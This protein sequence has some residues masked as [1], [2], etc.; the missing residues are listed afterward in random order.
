MK[1]RSFLPVLVLLAALPAA[2]QPTADGL[3]APAAFLGYELGSRFTPHHRVVAYVEHVTAHAPAVRLERYG[4]TNEGR[5]LL[6]ATVTTPANRDRLEQIRTDNLKRAG[7]LAGA[8]EGPP[9][10]VVWLSYNVH[11][12]ESVS[13]EAALQTL[14]ELA[15]PEDT[16]T[17]AWLANTVVLLDPCINPDGRDRYVHWY[18]ETV[19][20][21]PD[22]D[23]EARE[24]REPWPGGRANHYYF[25]LNR[26]WA[27]GTQQET[28]QRLARY[29]QWMPHI[30]V[31]FH[32]QGVDE[33]YFFAPAAEPFHN[34]VT[35]WQRE[36]QTRIGK[37]HTRYFDANH[38]LYFT[39]QRFDLFYPGYGDTWP[40]FNGAVGMTYEQGGSGRAGLGI[41]T[42]EGDTLTLADRIAHH[43]TTGLSTVETAARDAD[44]IVEEFTRYFE[45][46]RTAPAAPYAAYVVKA[47]N[48]DKLAALAAHL[49]AQGIA[50]GYATRTRTA[51]GTAYATGKAAGVTVEPGDLVV[52]AYQPRRVLASVLF[53]PD[54]VLSDS[55]S[56]DVTAW[57]LPY[58]YGL[59]AY[60]L[61]TRLDPDVDA[62]QDAAPPA[63]TGPDRPYAYLAEWRSFEDLQFLAAVLR[64]G[65][66]LRFAAAPFVIDGR[67]YGRGTLIL[68]R[69]GNQHLGDRFDRVVRRAAE[70]LRQPLHGV[71][72][73]FVAE[74]AD[75]G[76]SD[77]PFLDAPAVAVLAGDPVSSYAAGEVWHFF[78]QQLGYP[79]TLL[80]PDALGRIR[81]ADYDV[82][83]LPGGNYGSVLTDERLKELSAWIRDGGRLVALERAAAF[84]AGKEGFALQ[85]KDDGEAAEEKTPEEALR[86]YAERAR[87]A[88]SGD[89]TGAI[90]R[91]HL[92]P[93]HPLAFGY[94]DATFT[95]KRNDD[96]FAFLD[97][98]WNVGVLREDPPLGG[99]AGAK[100]QPPLQHSL[101]FGVQDLGRGA[102][103]Y[104]LDDVLFRGF[105]YN[106]RLLFGNAVFLAGRR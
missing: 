6:L 62:A 43:H 37:N 63:V 60:A 7:L 93:T 66:K 52:S 14:Y 97:D 39:R 1:V 96:A 36:L 46:A 9:V 26:D 90:F 55:L 105:W 38:W 40:T 84:L 99:F 18:T 21:F 56:Y 28:R 106:G 20:R 32:E 42:A 102:V 31:D 58:V 80:D 74:G 104:L 4:V 70:R 19:G 68:T 11:G 27:W 8:P 78:D 48:A 64:A 54:P 76:S 71:A 24:H 81:L 91:V 85:R 16:R 83:I 75:F 22:V 34:A 15:N 45:D 57:A 44:R 59:E 41:L 100:A 23:P 17:Q 47:G 29:Q 69:T 30:H 95:L 77:V 13:T 10:A 82:L 92:D 61:P 33:P 51:R 98:G 101:V 89:V 5:P 50:Y 86:P 87:E 67:S 88:I 79:V 3:L 2:A 72:T 65:V 94:G 35:G 12:N 25:D 103:V 73:G 49:D 53:D